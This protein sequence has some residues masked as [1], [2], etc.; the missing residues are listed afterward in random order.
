[1]ELRRVFGIEDM[2]SLDTY[3]DVK[4][5]SWGRRVCG[6]RQFH[7]LSIGVDGPLGF[8][9][10]I[11]LNSKDGRELIQSI[12]GSQTTDSL[13]ERLGG[14]SVIAYYQGIKLVGIEKR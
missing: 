11:E 7:Y 14:H 1:M 2:F 10:Q 3:I 9:N 6:S 5:I 13:P 12:T 4:N 8:N